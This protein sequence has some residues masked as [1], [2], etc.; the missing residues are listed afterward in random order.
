MPRK[1]N[2]SI[3]AKE[4]TQFFDAT[5]KTIPEKYKTEK[6][7]ILSYNKK[8]NELDIDFKGHGIRIKHAKNIETSIVSVK[9]TGEIGQ[10]NFSYWL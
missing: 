8:T 3:Q 1:K 2:E 6:C 5:R 7:K 10:T 4:S 9:Y